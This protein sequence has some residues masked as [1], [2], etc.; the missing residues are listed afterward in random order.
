MK[1]C[2][3]FT[4]NAK[5]IFYEAASSSFTKALRAFRYIFLA[6]VLA[7]RV[8]RNSALQFTS[9]ENPNSSPRIFSRPSTVSK[10]RVSPTFEDL[11]NNSLFLVCSVTNLDKS[12]DHFSVSV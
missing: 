8:I 7:S 9:V 11:E 1:S 10:I 12:P 4:E 2:D 3:N 6:C 5:T